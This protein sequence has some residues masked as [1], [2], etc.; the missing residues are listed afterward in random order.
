MRHTSLF[1]FYFERLNTSCDLSTF[2]EPVALS[3]LECRTPD[4]DTVHSDHSSTD[5][6]SRVGHAD[7]GSPGSALASSQGDV[8]VGEKFLD[9]SVPN[10][11]APCSHP[12]PGNETISN[13]PRSAPGISR[14]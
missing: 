13:D 5:P 10:L 2:V 1:V 9:D 8:R 7:A 6:A 11:P 3:H 4:F 12:P 14:R